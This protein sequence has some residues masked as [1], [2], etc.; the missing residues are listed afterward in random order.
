MVR[1]ILIKQIKAHWYCAQK[2]L[3]NSHFP[4]CKE[5]RVLQDLPL[6]PSCLSDLLFYLPWFLL[7]SPLQPPR[8]SLPCWTHSCSGHFPRLS[9]DW[10]P[11]LLQLTCPFPQGAFLDCLVKNTVPT[12]R[13]SST[14]LLLFLG[15]Y[16]HWTQYSFLIFF[17]ICFP[18]W[19]CKLLEVRDFC[20]IWF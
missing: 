12:L 2:L 4:P 3:V 9:E 18:Q 1:R 15:I 5:Y 13:F 8:F 14:F 11:H 10:P 20:W 19:K 6:L 7:W 17:I 16:L